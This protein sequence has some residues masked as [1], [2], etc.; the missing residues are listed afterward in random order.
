METLLPMRGLWAYAD[1]R[2]SSTARDAAKQASEVF[3][4]RKLFRRASDGRIIRPD[5]VALH[6]PRYWHYDILGG[7]KGMACMGRPRDPRCAEALDLLE[8]K[9]LTGAGWPAEAR[10]YRIRP[11]RTGWS[12]DFV[13]W[14][15]AAPKRANVWVSV[16]A[17]AVLRAADRLEI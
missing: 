6:Y 17:L 14:G 11:G 10:Y 1:L 15:G 2:R 13:D 16:D 7:L 9:R 8:K 3:V 4:Q 5:F 12:T